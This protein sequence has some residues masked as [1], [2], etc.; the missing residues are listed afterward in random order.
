MNLSLAESWKGRLHTEII[1]ALNESTAK[2]ALTKASSLGLSFKDL[3]EG[4][5]WARKK[6][7]DHPILINLET[8]AL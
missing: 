3:K 2:K 7:A 6:V 5:E 8:A 4:V 1:D